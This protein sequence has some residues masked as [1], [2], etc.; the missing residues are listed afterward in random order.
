M[1][2][3]FL[4]GKDLQDSVS[5]IPAPQSPEPSQITNNSKTTTSVKDYRRFNSHDRSLGSFSRKSSKHSSDGKSF[6][7]PPQQTSI[8]L[9]GN[10]IY[11]NSIVDNQEKLERK[12][13]HG[14]G[15]F[16]SSNAW[17][18]YGL[19]SW[20]LFIVLWRSEN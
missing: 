20:I 7:F 15:H 11:K 5:C 13:K 12:N 6:L 19:K 3:W 14:N 4:V 18:K 2:T 10:E 1:Q 16:F 17:I 9:E 8:S